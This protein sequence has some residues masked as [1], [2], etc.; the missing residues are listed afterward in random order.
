DPLGNVTIAANSRLVVYG[1]LLL[2]YFTDTDGDQYFDADNERILYPIEST[3]AYLKIEVPA[4]INPA[5]PRGTPATDMYAFPT[6][7]TGTATA[8]RINDNYSATCTT[9]RSVAT[10][11]SPID[12]WFPESEGMPYP[13][14]ALSRGQMALMDATLATGGLTGAAAQIIGTST[15]GT[16]ATGL[17]TNRLSYYYELMYATT[18]RDEPNYWPMSSS[19][20]TGITSMDNFYIGED[21]APSNE[22]DKFHLLFPNGYAHGWKVALAALDLSAENWN[23]LLDGGGV[24]R[25]V[26]DLYSQHVGALAPYGDAVHPVGSPF[27]V[28]GAINDPGLYKAASLLAEQSDY[29]YVTRDI[30]TDYGII[31]SN[32]RDIPTLA[33]SGGLVDTHAWNNIS[34]IIYTSSALEWETGNKGGTGY[35]SGS[36]ITG[37]GFYNKAKTHDKAHQIFVFDPQTVDNVSTKNMIF[38]MVRFFKQALH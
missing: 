8:N 9:C 35:V 22:G 24:G 17:F 1:M 29:F 6:I 14:G 36:V 23:T 31:D 16:D 20:P 5:M 3:D 13:G 2:D 33:Y 19:F 15:L 26:V 4:M 30:T 27:G 18:D 25:S 37:L 7:A 28:N 11:A 34:G 32:F 21:D 38:R 12:G 10:L